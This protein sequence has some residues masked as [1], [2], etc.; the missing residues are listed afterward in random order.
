MEYDEV[1]HSLRIIARAATRGHC[2]DV[3]SK[4]NDT[5][6][7]FC[8]DHY[9]GLKDNWAKFALLKSANKL[10]RFDFNDCTLEGVQ[11]LVAMKEQGTQYIVSDA[12]EQ[13]SV[14]VLLGLPE[15]MNR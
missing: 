9:P 12:G 11:G 14:R 4:L 8:G 1:L 7:D 3:F 15:G 2:R 10:A 5:F 6:E 13:F